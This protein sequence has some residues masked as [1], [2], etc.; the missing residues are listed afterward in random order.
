MSPKNQ[1]TQTQKSLFKSPDLPPPLLLSQSP[2][3]TSNLSCSPQSYSSSSSS[4]VSITSTS[5]K[6]S[7]MQS[8]STGNNNNNRSGSMLPPQSGYNSP[9]IST[10]GI[11]QWP[12]PNSSSMDKFNNNS[13]VIG[14]TSSD[15]L[16]SSSNND[17]KLQACL[18]TSTPSSPAESSSPLSAESRN[19]PLIIPTD[20]IFDQPSTQPTEQG[21]TKFKESINDSSTS[22]IDS[23]Y[24]SDSQVTNV[25]TSTMKTFQSLLSDKDN[26]VSSDSIN[27]SSS[28]MTTTVAASLSTS[29]GSS[30]TSGQKSIDSSNT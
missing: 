29:D 21:H 3:G 9:G 15:H 19:P 20:P 27:S 22:Q 1:P 13:M 18:S 23:S 11:T 30:T 12:S 2:T 28:S 16:T 26:L 6:P 14:S 25:E 17:S 24:T 5:S 4:S 7:L 10:T 8:I